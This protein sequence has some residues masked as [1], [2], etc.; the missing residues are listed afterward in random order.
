MEDTLLIKKQLLAEQDRT[1]DVINKVYNAKNMEDPISFDEFK[2][3]YFL[4]QS[5]G[6]VWT[7]DDLNANWLYY[8]GFEIEPNLECQILIPVQHFWNHNPKPNSVM[9]FDGRS[10]NIRALRSLRSGEELFLDYKVPSNDHMLASFGFTM[11]HT[12][13]T[14]KISVSEL[15][16]LCNEVFGP[17]NAELNESKCKEIISE[18]YEEIYGDVLD[19]ESEESIREADLF[20]S[21]TISA[22]CTL[23]QPI[24]NF[25][26][27]QAIGQT[28]EEESKKINTVLLNYKMK[29]INE[30]RARLQKNINN[31]TA[32]ETFY[33][34]TVMDLLDSKQSVIEYCLRVF[35]GELEHFTFFH[36]KYT[37]GKL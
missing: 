7:V 5:R 27:H 32:Q 9:K 14:M 25:V 6:V 28:T 26:A 33:V 31:F 2:Y 10:L 19:F 15:I 1:Y 20:M 30:K 35:R 21:D 23:N 22:K 16:H 29:K 37:A 18:G 34:T 24:L 3:A 11:K 4:H 36:E 8:S 12:K 13:E 17:Q